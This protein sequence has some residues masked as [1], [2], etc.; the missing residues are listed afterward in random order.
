MTLKSHEIPLF[1]SMFYVSGSCISRKNRI[2]FSCG[3]QLWM[4]FITASGEEPS[5]VTLY[6]YDQR[7]CMVRVINPMA[8]EQVYVYDGN[9]NP[10]TVTDEEGNETT[11]RY[12]L[13][14]QPVELCYG[15]GRQAVFRYNRRGELVEMKDWN[16]TAVM[17]HDLLGRLTKVT[18]HNGNTT[19]YT[20]DAAGNRISI[21]Y[22]DESVVNYTYDGN[23]R[24]TGVTDQ[25]DAGTRYQ[26]DPAGNL[27]SAVQPGSSAA[28]TYNA[29][30]KP[31]TVEYRAGD[32]SFLTEEET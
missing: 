21:H 16:G 5:C 1:F 20:Y 32:G 30:G 27:L 18:D 29:A 9:G 13:N 4:T 31:V 8:E 19:G 3:R 17:E 6:Q 15:D 28:Y 23:H 22:P 12:D 10:V 26:Y 25:N 11:V 7:G 2:A 24:L 14:N